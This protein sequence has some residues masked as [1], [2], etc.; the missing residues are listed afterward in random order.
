MVTIAVFSSLFTLGEAAAQHRRDH[1]DHRSYRPYVAHRHVAP[2][3][4][5]YNNHH[6]RRTSRNWAPYIAGGLALGA[7]GGFYYNNQQQ[8]RCWIETQDMFTR[9]GQY[10]GTQQVRVCN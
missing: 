1:R 8:T 5:F 2:P 7:L 9:R 6:H 10:L 4:R 3:V